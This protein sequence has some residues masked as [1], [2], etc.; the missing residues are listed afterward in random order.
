MTDHFK[1]RIGYFED[2]KHISLQVC[3]DYNLGEFKLNIPIEMG[4]EDFNFVLK[5]SSGKYFVKIFAKSRNLEECQRYLDIMEKVIQNKILTPKLLSSSQGFMYR[6]SIQ[7]I[8]I[9]LCV[10]EFVNGKTLFELED[11][12]SIEDIK[13]IARQVSLINLIDL[14]TEKVYDT[15]AIT[16]FLKEF[17]RKRRVLSRK[18]LALIEPLVKKFEEMKINELPHCFIHGD[19]RTTNVMRDINNKLWIIDFSV[20]GYYPRIQ[21]IAVLACDLLFD[22]ENYDKSKNNLKIFLKEYQQ[23]LNHSGL[24][25]QRFQLSWAESPGVC[26]FVPHT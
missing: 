2:V 9:R 10:A 24:K 1:K 22:R 19:I 23:T 18:D 21:E 7:G 26:L 14:R 5:A 25:V 6:K 13:F 20:S 8:E 3:K 4:Y 12:L 16:N 17:E 15:W 11:G